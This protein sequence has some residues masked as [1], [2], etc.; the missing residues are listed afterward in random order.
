MDWGERG[1]T[2][3]GERGGTG[4]ASSRRARAS[5]RTARF[6]NYFQLFFVFLVIAFY[7]FLFLPIPVHASYGDRYNADLDLQ[8]PMLRWPLAPYIHTYTFISVF[9]SESSNTSSTLE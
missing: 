7:S 9:I 6:A 1:G 5:S 8:R 3:W 4:R 2:G